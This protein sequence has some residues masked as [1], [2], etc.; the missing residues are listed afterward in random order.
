M[1]DGNT[2]TYSDRSESIEGFDTYTVTN[3]DSSF[4]VQYMS[5][6]ALGTVRNKD[7]TYNFNPSVLYRKR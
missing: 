3:S 7:T 1:D 6:G 4:T 5:G 2:V